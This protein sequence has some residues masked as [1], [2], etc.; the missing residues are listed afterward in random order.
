[1]A[2]PTLQ[3]HALTR[4]LTRWPAE[5]LT[6]PT[7]VTEGLNWA[8]GVATAHRLA[9]PALQAS[10]QGAVATAGVLAG[11]ASNVVWSAAFE[12]GGAFSMY[13]GAAV[14]EVMA[15]ASVARLAKD[16]TTRA[17]HRVDNELGGVEGVKVVDMAGGSAHPDHDGTRRSRRAQR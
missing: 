8:I 1:M 3:N 15:L 12:M 5:P 17:L 2:H 6:P 13:A 11:S 9:P 14:F 7:C 16:G 4:W 10:A